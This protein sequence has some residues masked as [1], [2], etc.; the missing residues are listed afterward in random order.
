MGLLPTRTAP[1]D[2]SGK[3]L[4]SAP[5]SFRRRPESSGLHN[6]FPRSGNDNH[7]NDNRTRHRINLA[8]PALP[9]LAP[10]DSSLRWN[11]GGGSAWVCCQPDSPFCHV[12]QIPDFSPLR[13]SGAGRN[14]VIETLH[15]RASGNDSLRQAT[16][17]VTRETRQSLMSPA[18]PARPQHAGRADHTIIE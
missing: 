12:W 17:S 2:M 7:R 18:P 14:P 6:P 1:S 3:F 11:D 10:L 15:S 9:G 4:T 16:Q 13:H 5:P 8:T